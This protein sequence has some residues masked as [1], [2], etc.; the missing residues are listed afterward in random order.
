MSSFPASLAA[1]RESHHLCCRGIKNNLTEGAELAEKAEETKIRFSP[2]RALRLREI[3]SV[4][5]V[6]RR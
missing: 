6:A 3:L 2:P 5:R 1:L 4:R